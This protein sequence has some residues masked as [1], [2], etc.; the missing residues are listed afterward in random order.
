MTCVATWCVCLVLYPGDRLRSRSDKSRGN[1]RLGPFQG[2][3]GAGVKALLWST[4]HVGLP[5]LVLG[6]GGVGGSPFFFL[7]CLVLF[8]V[9]YRGQRSQRG[10]ILIGFFLCFHF[11]FIYLFDF[12][13]WYFE[14]RDDMEPSQKDG[15]PAA[16]KSK[17][18]SFTIYLWALKENIL[19]SRKVRKKRQFLL[20]KNSL[21]SFFSSF[22]LL[23][24]EPS[25]CNIESNWT[26]LMR[27]ISV[28][29]SLSSPV[30]L[31][32][33]W[34][35]GLQTR[36]QKDF[37]NSDTSNKPSEVCGWTCIFL[38]NNIR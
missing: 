37:V 17:T 35:K 30:S 2:P 5:F 36:F 26:Y 19:P 1:V 10:A 31:W 29:H 22:L 6:S 4:L 11:I 38:L 15:W 23:L 7:Y 18:T 32:W 21:C 13:C 28:Q 24:R 8:C 34:L 14:H 3:T 9:L 25:T 12:V 33:K 16:M 27:S 20:S